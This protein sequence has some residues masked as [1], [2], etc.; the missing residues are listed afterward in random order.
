MIQGRD[1]VV[2]GIQPWDIKIGSNCKNLA[3]EF[4]KNNRVLYVNQPLDIKTRLFKGHSE[5]VKFR[6]NV[7]RG[8]KKA[9]VEVDNNHWTFYP[10]KTVLS[11]NRVPGRLFYDYLNQKNNQVF[12][13]EIQWAINELGFKDIILFND[14][15]MFLGYYLKELLN[16]SLAIYYIRDNLITQPYFKRHGK[17]ME[18]ELAKKYDI[19]V[20]NS[21]YL[22]NYLRKYNDHTFMVGQGCSLELFNPDNDE[23]VVPDDLASLSKP[24][25][26]YIGNLTSIRLDIDLLVYLA[27]N[28]PDFNFVLIGPEDEKFQNSKLHQT[29][30][31]Y[32]LGSKNEYE[33]PSYLKGFDVAINPQAINQL[34]VG[35]YPRKIDEYLAMGKPTVVTYTETM[36]YF[37][38]NV[39][40]SK[41]FEE[42]SVNLKKALEENN[43]ELV[44]KR[45]KCAGEH[46]WENNAKNIY[47]AIDKI[48]QP[49]KA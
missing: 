24:I 47:E 40:A 15:L 2:I 45:I 27:E 14:S 3:I 34:T 38:D 31:V 5:E 36:E 32:F 48:A 23:L 18:P 43:A 44:E 26:G 8:E 30:N 1:I 9:L 49:V 20:S 4:A 22:A 39:Y 42:F 13:N 11:I 19:V 21:T 35:N 41:D 29:K 10:R 17:E 12:A 7:L 33:L 37:G 25:I 46:T 28:N 6:L 16:P